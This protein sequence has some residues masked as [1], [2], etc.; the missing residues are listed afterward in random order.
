M[1]IVI[2]KITL[3]FSNSAGRNWWYRCFLW[4]CP[5]ILRQKLWFFCWAWKNSRKTHIDMPQRQQR[6]PVGLGMETG[7]NTDKEKAADK[8]VE[9]SLK[10]SIHL[11]VSVWQQMSTV[12]DSLWYYNSAVWDVR[13][14]S[15]YP[16][17]SMRW[18]RNMQRRALLKCIIA[19]EGLIFRRLRRSSF[20]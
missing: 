12:M 9:L 11:K 6:M 10:I 15:G 8:K 14:A 19:D 17:P 7:L 2:S 20:N 4:R 13:T 16:R 1:L 18:W 5:E 3:L